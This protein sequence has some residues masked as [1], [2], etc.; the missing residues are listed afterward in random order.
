MRTVGRCGTRP[1]L[2]DDNDH[3]V[4]PYVSSRPNLFAQLDLYEHD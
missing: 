3:L 4:A 2:S 1:N